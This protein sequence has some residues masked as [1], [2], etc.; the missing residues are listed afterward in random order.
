MPAFRGNDQPADH[1]RDNT[2]IEPGYGV[3]SLRIGHIIT[4]RDE[5]D[6]IM[7]WV[8]WR[9]LATCKQMQREML[10]QNKGKIG[11]SPDPGKK[12]PEI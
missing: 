11:V 10:H 1:E 6:Y 12:K 7:K 5:I 2:D 4:M 8:C 9:Y 3:P